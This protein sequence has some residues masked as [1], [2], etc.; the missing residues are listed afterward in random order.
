MWSIRN[1]RLLTQFLQVD[2]QNHSRKEDKTEKHW[3]CVWSTFKL[4][5]MRNTIFFAHVSK[6]RPFQIPLYISLALQNCIVVQ[7]I[8]GKVSKVQAPMVLMPYSLQ[9]RIRVLQCRKLLLLPLKQYQALKFS[10]NT[11][12][13]GLGYTIE[14]ISSLSGRHCE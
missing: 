5:A 14:P 7:T 12:N 8:L 1:A 9:F 4:F 3:A 10:P 6:A 2:V 11:N 13:R